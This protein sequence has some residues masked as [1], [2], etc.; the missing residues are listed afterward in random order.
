MIGNRIRG[1]ID[2]ILSEAKR[3]Q[4]DQKIEIRFIALDTQAK[5]VRFGNDVVRTP[6]VRFPIDQ[7]SGC[8]AGVKREQTECLFRALHAEPIWPALHL[9]L[10]GGV[11]GALKPLVLPGEDEPAHTADVP[12]ILHHGDQHIA[13]RRLFHIALIKARNRVYMRFTARSWNAK[14]RDQHGHRVVGVQL[15]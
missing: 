12:D 4:I 1:D 9:F 11:P 2:D 6:F 8:F 13:L 3:T 5:A 7:H 14:L 10:I 15:H